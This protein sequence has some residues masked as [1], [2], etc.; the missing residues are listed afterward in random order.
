M[1]ALGPCYSHRAPAG[2]WLAAWKMVLEDRVLTP[3]QVRYPGGAC[4]SPPAQ[5][6]HLASVAPWSRA[7]RHMLASRLMRSKPARK[8][9]SEATVFCDFQ[10]CTG[11]GKDRAVR[12]ASRGIFLVEEMSKLLLRCWGPPTCFCEEVEHRLHLCH[13]PSINLRLAH[14]CI[15]SRKRLTIEEGRRERRAR[16]GKSAQ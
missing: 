2:H 5:A 16:Q 4:P 9:L 10:E 8:I 3:R 6:L 14:S 11:S 1:A 12:D 15:P 7:V 13:L